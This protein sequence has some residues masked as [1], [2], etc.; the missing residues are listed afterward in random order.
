[1]AIGY[2]SLFKVPAD[3]DPIKFIEDHIRS[4]LEEKH[5]NSSTRLSVTDWARPGIHELGTGVELRLAHRTIDEPSRDYRLYR[6]AETTNLGR[7]VVSIYVVSGLDSNDKT[8]NVAIE[9]DHPS[10]DPTTAILETGTP[11]LVGQI[12]NSLKIFDGRAQIT[13]RPIRITRKNSAVLIDAITGPHRNA[14]VIA[15]GSPSD[16]ADDRWEEIVQSLTRNSVGLAAVYSVDADALAEIDD[17]LGPSHQ[18]GAGHVRTY[19]PRVNLKDA[20]DAVRHRWLAPATLT[21]SLT[22]YFKVHGEL[23][24]TH[25]ASIRRRF[26]EREIPSSIT[27][28]MAVLRREERAMHRGSIAERDIAAAVAGMAAEATIDTPPVVHDVIEP[29]FAEEGKPEDIQVTA[30]VDKP[31]ITQKFMARIKRLVDRWLPQSTRSEVTPESLSELEMFIVSINSQLKTSQEQITELEEA[32]EQLEAEMLSSRTLADDLE[33]ELTLV[34]GDSVDR[35]RHISELWTTIAKNNIRT[36]ELDRADNDWAAPG[37]M[38][39][40]VNL[41]SPGNEVH[42]AINFV[43]F[44]GATDGAKQMDDRYKAGRYNTTIWQGVRALHD[45]AAAKNNGS[46]NGDFFMYLNSPAVTGQKIPTKQYAPR[47]SESVK[48]NDRWRGM[49]NFPVPVDVDP[50]GYAYMDAH[51]KPSHQDTF[52]PRVH[53]YDD[54]GGATGKIYVGYVGRHLENTLTASI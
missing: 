37:S 4:W 48:N 44:T 21:R 31:G 46:F 25:A 23:Q 38:E 7:F 32:N 20:D 49:R 35:E 45:Y 34:Q 1:M 12:L 41:L 16:D 30:A 14:A 39:E 3:K 2:R 9:V 19:E 10:E 5:L 54:T 15:A 13:G 51:L 42:K 40:L 53:F 27:I 29:Q 26:I 18:I 28:A 43:Q 22:P 47:E 36:L 11:R 50:S 52:A 6:L 24:S 17:E 33:I 8:P